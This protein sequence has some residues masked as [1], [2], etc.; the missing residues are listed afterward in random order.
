MQTRED[1]MTKSEVALPIGAHATVTLDRDEVLLIEGKS[2]RVTWIAKSGRF[3]QWGAQYTRQALDLIGKRHSFISVGAGRWLNGDRLRSILWTRKDKCYWLRL[4]SNVPDA[5]SQAA[6]SQAAGSRAAGS[7]G[8][9][10][11]VRVDEAMSK[12]IAASLGLPH[13]Y[14]V[15]PFPDLHRALWEEGLR[16]YPREIFQMSAPELQGYFSGD[17]GKI[18]RNLIWQLFRWRAQGCEPSYDVTSPR[19][20]LYRPVSVVLNR[21]GLLQGAKKIESAAMEA[22]DALSPV[23]LTMAPEL[24]LPGDGTINAGGEWDP[25]GG[26]KGAGAFGAGWEW[27]P[28]GGAKG[29][30]AF[31]AGGV[32]GGGAPGGME[33]YYALLLRILVE[34][35]AE[36]RL[37]TYYDLGFEDVRPD[38]RRIGKS[39]PRTVLVV[40]KYSLLKALDEASQTRGISGIVL[41]GNPSWIPTEYFCRGLRQAIG[42]NEPV[43]LVSLVD[44]DPFG[45]LLVEMF[46]EQLDRYGVKTASVKHLVLPERFSPEEIRQVSYQVQSASSAIQGKI[47]KWMEAGGGIEGKPLGI[48]ADD[49][50]PRQR[51][52]DAIDAVCGFQSTKGTKDGSSGDAMRLAGSGYNGGGAGMPAENR[53]CNMADSSSSAGDP[54]TADSSSSVSDPETGDSLIFAAKLNRLV[55]QGDVETGIVLLP[56]EE[57]SVVRSEYAGRLEIVSVNR[58]VFH[59]SRPL[60]ELKKALGKKCPGFVPVSAAALVNRA[61]V[62]AVRPVSPHRWVLDLPGGETEIM[63]PENVI[64]KA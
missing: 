2:G 43:H 42:E 44:Y 16:D 7:Q 53:S 6:G 61:H 23:W 60:E 3:I 34:L 10:M 50:W 64:T 25:A 5:G 48:H 47:R 36:R 57:V 52:M 49:L 31:G 56:P 38:L 59:L 54:A 32:P 11:S 28:A 46:R 55:L 13:L 29:A 15:E 40:E 14:H 1:R 33:Y 26:A 63:E 58:E 35:S 41:G 20:F 19:G 12:K 21:M 37:F 18:I 30:G 39:H 17:A 27:D 51:I 8:S 62:Q 22:F 4:D 9:G 45:W 24:I